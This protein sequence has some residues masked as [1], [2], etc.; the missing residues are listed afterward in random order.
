M[1]G[2]TVDAT[3][4]TPTLD[5]QFA[6]VLDS[7]MHYVESGTGTPIVH[8]HGNPTSS[9]LWRNVLPASARPG[10]AIARRDA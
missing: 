2:V 4:H 9:S 3:L 6:D 7:R 8:L 10:R 5:G 1:T